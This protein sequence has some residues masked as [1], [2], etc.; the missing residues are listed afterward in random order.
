MSHFHTVKFDSNMA[1]LEVHHI[2]R[3]NSTSTSSLRWHLHSI[4]GGTS[5][6]EQH[7]DDDQDGSKAINSK[8]WGSITSAFQMNIDA[9]DELLMQEQES[10]EDMNEEESSAT[11][12]ELNNAT[13]E[14]TSQE[15]NGTIHDFDSSSDQDDIDGQ[16]HSV[17]ETVE[18]VAT[19]S[20]RLAQDQDEQNFESEDDDIASSSEKEEYDEEEE[21]Q[22]EMEKSPEIEE[23]EDSIDPPEIEEEA[24]ESKDPPE[25]E[26]V[27]EST[28][29][30]Q[31][32]LAPETY[33]FE[34][35]LE[36]ENDEVESATDEDTYIDDMG[37]DNISIYTDI[38]ST[39]DSEILEQ[40]ERSAGSEAEGDFD[41]SA[42][43]PTLEEIVREEWSMIPETEG[44]DEGKENEIEEELKQESPKQKK[45]RKKDK[46]NKKD[47]KKR[48]TD[49]MRKNE[50]DQNIKNADEKPHNESIAEG[51]VQEVSTSAPLALVEERSVIIQQ[52]QQEQESPFVS[53]GFVSVSNDYFLFA[54]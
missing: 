44:E 37:G 26:E 20:S 46:K 35:A 11:D 8:F 42:I 36:D 29:E 24:V 50:M 3:T 27:V 12:D 33:E 39:S 14:E 6:N 45:K 47:K 48:E 15:L 21:V 17:F 7:D 52:I 49:R 30:E 19:A 10:N 28:K 2:T 22:E 31:E 38:S 41:L 13:V 51:E 40:E 25:I 54:Y 34:D 4:R 32:M 43:L 53:S 18:E 5:S 9:K 16:G 1:S 23:V